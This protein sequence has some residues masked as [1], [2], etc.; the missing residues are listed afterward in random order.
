MFFTFFMLQVVS[1]N[2]CCSYSNNDFSSTLELDNYLQEVDNTDSINGCF[3]DN[4]F[5]HVVV[6]N[7][8]RRRIDY[9][10]TIATTEDNMEQVTVATSNRT[11]IGIQSSCIAVGHG[12]IAICV[13][14]ASF[15]H[16]G[17]CGCCCCCQ[18]LLVISFA[19]LKTFAT[20]SVFI[21]YPYL[22]FSF[23]HFFIY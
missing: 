6:A 14:D 19:S 1:Y 21:I 8:A 22:Y 11:A 13:A 2:M 17:G 5:H 15:D 18:S 23:L 10:S 16:R 20:N 12:R 7:M 9:N 3:A 4:C